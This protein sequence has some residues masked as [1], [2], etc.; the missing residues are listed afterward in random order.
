MVY[1]FYTPNFQYWQLLNRCLCNLTLN[2]CQ[3]CHFFNPA[4]SPLHPFDQIRILIPKSIFNPFLSAIF[5]VFSQKSHLNRI[6]VCFSLDLCCMAVPMLVF[7]AW[8][9]Q[10]LMRVSS[11]TCSRTYCG[12]LR[13]SL[14]TKTVSSPNFS[15]NFHCIHIYYKRMIIV[16]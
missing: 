1:T 9:V 4:H 11:R 14:R 6:L 8:I 13:T 12:C 10:K 7:A 3:C 15:P 2:F 16:M 5:V